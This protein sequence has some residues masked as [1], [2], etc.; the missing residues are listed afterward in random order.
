M[1]DF[2]IS[3]SQTLWVSYSIKKVTFKLTRGIRKILVEEDYI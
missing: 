3:K 2:N 1:V